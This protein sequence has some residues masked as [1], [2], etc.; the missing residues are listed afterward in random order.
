MTNHIFTNRFYFVLIYSG[1]NTATDPYYYSA[2][3]VAAIQRSSASASSSL[4]PTSP[5]SITGSLM[6][7][8]IGG[9]GQQRG[10]TTVAL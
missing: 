7:G 8:N 10:Q 6:I 1:A 3:N 4:T 5:Q 2:V 9:G